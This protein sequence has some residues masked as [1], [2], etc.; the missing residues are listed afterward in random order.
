MPKIT[1]KFKVEGM[2][3]DSCAKMIELDMEDIGVDAK[4][5]YPKELLSVEYDENKTRE[6]EIIKVI[7]SSGYKMKQVSS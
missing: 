5:S 6:D 1:I 3:C 2:D 7:K 4:C